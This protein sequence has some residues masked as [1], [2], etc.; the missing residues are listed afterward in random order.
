MPA[1]SRPTDETADEAELAAAAE[2]GEI[3]GHTST[4]GL[5]EAER[6]LAEAGE[7]E[8]EGFELA[9][10]QLIESASHGDPSG[11]PQ[12]RPLPGRGRGVGGPGRATVR[13]TTSA[14][15][16]RT[17]ETI[18][19]ATLNERRNEMS[20]SF[21]ARASLEV[22]GREYEI[23]RLDALQSKYDVARLPYSIKVLLENVLRLE[24]GE[25]V[26]ADDVETIATWDAKAEPS[27][28]IPF[29]PARVS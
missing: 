18:E 21:G 12:R 11:H 5:P 4:Q 16:R 1:S 19:R 26:T 6:P 22:G 9:E 10:E 2:A 25:S 28:E 3:G 14:C 20:D 27:K 13:P 15:P 17:T 8:A 24:D 23:H 7:G 29:Q